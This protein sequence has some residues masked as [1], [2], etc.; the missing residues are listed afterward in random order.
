MQTFT[1]GGTYLSQWGSGPGAGDGQ[2]TGPRG[3]GLDGSGN[4]YVADTGNN[5]IEVFRSTGA[6]VDKFGSLGTGPGQFSNPNGIVVDG[7]GNMYVADTSNN[8]IQEFGSL[9]TPTQATSWGRVK[10]LYR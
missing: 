9:P 1:T 8:R 5:R 3:I 4:V 2:F 7:S 6:F 10:S